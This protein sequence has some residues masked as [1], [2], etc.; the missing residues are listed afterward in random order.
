M[1]KYQAS[2]NGRKVNAQGITSNFMTEVEANS[3]QQAELKLYDTY[4][5]ISNLELKAVSIFIKKG[6][7][8]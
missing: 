7:N 5:H 4:E 3:R 8:Q 6:S 1:T 2:F